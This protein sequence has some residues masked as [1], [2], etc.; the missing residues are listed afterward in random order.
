MLC[1]SAGLCCMLLLIACSFVFFFWEE[2]FWVDCNSACLETV[3]SS[4]FFL[5]SGLRFSFGGD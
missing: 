2:S 1:F 3:V 4:C 5:V